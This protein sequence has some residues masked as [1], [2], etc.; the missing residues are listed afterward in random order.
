MLFYL[1]D[2]G[3]DLLHVAGGA[4]KNILANDHGFLGALISDWCRQASKI[5]GPPLYEIL[6]RRLV[7]HACGESAMDWSAF[8]LNQ[9]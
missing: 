2:G 6:H 9:R 3:Y 8:G 7:R 5:F 1:F 4:E